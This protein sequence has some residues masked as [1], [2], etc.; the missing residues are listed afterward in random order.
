MNGN[1]LP[2]QIELTSKQIKKQMVIGGLWLVVSTIM[3]LVGTVLACNEV[4]GLI[5][6]LLILAGVVAGIVGLIIMAS[7][8]AKAWWHHG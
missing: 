4:A 2:R 8:K 1:S 6:F 7:A 5:A 3:C